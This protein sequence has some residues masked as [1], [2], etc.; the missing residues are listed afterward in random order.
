[1]YFLY[2]LLYHDVFLNFNLTNRIS[3]KARLLF[4]ALHIVIIL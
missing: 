1:M 2:E 3:K 4:S